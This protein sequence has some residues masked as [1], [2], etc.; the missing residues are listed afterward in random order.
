MCGTSCT[1]T[2]HRDQPSLDLDP[3]GAGAVGVQAS[4]SIDN[5]TPKSH[6]RECY[7]RHVSHLVVAVLDR[8]WVASLL[9]EVGP[10]AG[11]VELRAAVQLNRVPLLIGEHRDGLAVDGR[12]PRCVGLLGLPALCSHARPV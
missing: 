3:L 9:H 5:R 6:A 11:V 7:P 2:A 10:E 1:D 12:H 8:N 4:D